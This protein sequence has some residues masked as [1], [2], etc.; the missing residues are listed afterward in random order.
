MYEVAS[1]GAD[2]VVYRTES[3]FNAIF[4]IESLPDGDLKTGRDLYDSVVLPATRPMGT[5]TEFRTVRNAEQLAIA[6]SDVARCIH[7][8]GHLPILH[9][10][11]HGTG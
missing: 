3:R 9:F 2:A 4:A 7:L 8:R 1:V 10:E 11:T 5:H 6:L